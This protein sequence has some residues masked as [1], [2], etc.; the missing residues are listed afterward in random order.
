MGSHRR[1]TLSIHRQQR[2][3]SMPSF[4]VRE[5][6]PPLLSGYKWQTYQSVTH[7][8]RSWS[9]R[10]TFLIG[11]VRILSLIWTDQW[12]P[13]GVIVTTCIGRMKSHGSVTKLRN[14]SESGAND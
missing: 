5:M 9:R 13:P 10:V 12:P 4:N 1:A 11:S 3:P 6:L 7:I 8:T 14:V 2:T